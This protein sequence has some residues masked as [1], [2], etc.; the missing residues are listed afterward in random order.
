MFTGEKTC[1]N[2]HKGIA[3]QLPGMAAA[4]GKDHAG[5]WPPLAGRAA[6]HRTAAP[7]RPFRRADFAPQAYSGMLP[8]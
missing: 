7:A 3:H 4:E 5:A 6:A 1:I 8:R 2:C